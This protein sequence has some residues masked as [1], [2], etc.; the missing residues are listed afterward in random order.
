MFSFLRHKKPS[1]LFT[2]ILPVHIVYW[3]DLL[4]VNSPL[5]FLFILNQSTSTH[6][7]LLSTRTGSLVTH[8]CDPRPFPTPPWLPSHFIDLES[9][10]MSLLSTPIFSSV[11][12]LLLHGI[13]STV[14][15]TENRCPFSFNTFPKVLFLQYESKILLVRLMTRF[16]FTTYSVSLLRSY[17]HQYEWTNHPNFT[18]FACYRLLCSLR[19]SFVIRGSD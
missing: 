15:Q 4:V 6:P 3:T 7:F 19:T 5:T 16:D 13:Y 17:H 14:P 2:R 8:T 12:N 1:Q 9:V 10:T 11:Y 18:L